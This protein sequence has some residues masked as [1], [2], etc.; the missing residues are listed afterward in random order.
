MT[1]RTA[2]RSYAPSAAATAKARMMP[3]KANTTSAIRIMTESTEPAKKPAM[4]PRVEPIIMATA[5]RRAAKG[6]ERRAPYRTRLNTS[7]PSSSV[8]NR[9][10]CDG[11]ALRGANWRFGG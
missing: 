11:A 8:P 5:T 4:A 7:R 10:R 3:G 9:Y 6:S 2:L 1:A